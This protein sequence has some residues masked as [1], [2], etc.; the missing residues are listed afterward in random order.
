MGYGDNL[1][2]IGDAYSM[3]MGQPEDRKRKVA[4]GNG[5]WLTDLGDLTYGLDDFLI[6][7]Q[8]EALKPGTPWVISKPGM[9]PYIDYAAMRVALRRQGIII[10]KQNKL[11]SR[12]GRYMWNHGYKPTPAPF[13]LKDSELEIAERARAA[14]PF[15]AVEPFLKEG[16]PTAKQYPVERMREV[17]LRLAKDIQVFQISHPS[18]P[19]LDPSIPRIQSNGFRQTLAYLKASTLYV[20]PE[21]G[22]HHGSAAVGTRAVVIFGGYIP[23]TVTGYDFHVNLTGDSKQACGIRTGC[24]HCIKAMNS[25][26]VD[27]IVRHANRQIE[28]EYA[29]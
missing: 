29:L 19:E 3:W 26:T 24:N 28:L 11:V 25:I 15:V 20:G 8:Q 16:A 27:E 21:G 22:L 6:L 23:P 13:V 1:M 2:A 10:E 12:L 9:R 4:I 14:G 17:A 7:N 5:A 18:A